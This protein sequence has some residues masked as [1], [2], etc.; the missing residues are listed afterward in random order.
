MKPFIKVRNLKKT[1]VL[2]PQERKEQGIRKKKAVKG[3]S[4]TVQKGECFGL[5][6][7]LDSGKTTVLRALLSRL[8][9]RKRQ[10][11][12]DGMP[13]YL[14]RSKDLISAEH[15]LEASFYPQAY[16]DICASK[17]HLEERENVRRRDMLF[18]KFGLSDVDQD[19]MKDLPMELQKR[20]SLVLGMTGDPEVIFYD[21]AREPLEEDTYKLLIEYL[22]DMRA[23]GKTIIMAVQW[24][25]RFVEKMCDR[26]GIMAKGNLIACDTME[27]I[28]QGRTLRRRYCEIYAEYIQSLISRYAC[29]IS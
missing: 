20:L 1:Y 19:L 29:V 23:K 25:L 24:D 28:C 12:I 9:T 4:F 5:I 3:V 11:T 2:G 15:Y 17:W 16:Y 21:E 14:Y 18:R 26:V 10:I 13:S 8:Q 27:N 7:P 22:E 6:G